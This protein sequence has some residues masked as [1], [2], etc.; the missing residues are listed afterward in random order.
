MDRVCIIPLCIFAF[1]FS[2]VSCDIFTTMRD[3]KDL[4]Q[5]ENLQLA[6]LE[7]HLK[8]SEERLNQI[9]RWDFVYMMIVHIV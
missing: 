5:L 3:L 2:F 4:S 9:K 6:K 1:Y 8:H 7:E